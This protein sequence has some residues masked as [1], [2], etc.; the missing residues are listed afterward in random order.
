M[1]VR[2]ICETA[3]NNEQCLFYFGDNIEK[4]KAVMSQMCAARAE[5]LVRTFEEIKSGA[6]RS[7]SIEIAVRTE[8]GEFHGWCVLG[9]VAFYGVNF[10]TGKIKRLPDYKLFDASARKAVVL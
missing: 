1:T 8:N 5:S 7:Q 6:S 2:E 10:K 9:S 4:F 3:K